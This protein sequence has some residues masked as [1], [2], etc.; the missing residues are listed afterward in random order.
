MEMPWHERRWS[1]VF[2][3]MYSNHCIA[4]GFVILF[5]PM[6]AGISLAYFHLLIFGGY[7][8]GTLMHKQRVAGIMMT[9]AVCL[10]QQ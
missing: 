2:A 7:I 3:I 5:N 8:V 10:M 9:G 4:L 1:K 6:I